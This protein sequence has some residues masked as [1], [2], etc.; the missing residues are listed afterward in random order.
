VEG[1]GIT[2]VMWG[3]I[4]VRDVARMEAN[5]YCEK[6]DMTSFMEIL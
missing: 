5:T 4:I 1:G 6:G 3:Q 2:S